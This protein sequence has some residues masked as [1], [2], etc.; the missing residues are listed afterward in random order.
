MDKYAIVKLAGKQ[1]K[2]SEGDE[3]AVDRLKTEPG[4]KFIVDE[5]LLVKDDDELQ[6]G[7]PTVKDAQVEF[8]V[9]EEYRDKKIRVAKYKAKSRYR[10]VR[11]HRQ[12]KSKVKVLSIS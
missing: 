5:V 9:E 8:E 11:G 3:F 10:R 7:T 2:V 12:H 6:I 4:E 1:F